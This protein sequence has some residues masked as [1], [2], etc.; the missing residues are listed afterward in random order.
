MP[1]GLRL[2]LI[3]ILFS[4]LLVPIA[5]GK[6]LRDPISIT[7]D[8]DFVT[9][10]F[11]GVGTRDN[12][13]RIEDLRIEAGPGR[14][15]CIAVE[16]TTAYFLIKNCELYS[17]YLGVSVMDV[18]P[19]TATIEGNIITGTTGDGGGITLSADGVTVLRNT[20]TNFVEGIHT[21]FAE[22][23]YILYNNFSQNEYHG[24]SL[25]YSNGN[26]VAHN[27]I[28]GNQ[29]HGVII[30][31]GSGN[32]ILFNNTFI[33]NSVIESYDWDD[34]YSFTVTSQGVDT[35]QS[36]KWYDEVVMMG[37]RWSDYSGEGEYA[38]DGE[39]RAVDKYPM[40]LTQDAPEAPEEP[41]ES[42]GGIPGYPFE[43]IILGLAIFGLIIKLVN[44]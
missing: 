11:P 20:C 12:P 4:L 17:S 19:D 41:E 39:G 26:L 27:I 44:R 35:A 8:E 40:Q 22:D 37:N 31:R 5:Q 16:G 6:E 2:V 29:A 38:I 30:I 21:N 10:G 24:V 18:A 23:C 13:Y 36:N 43:A 42:S 7:S 33:D 32:N 28:E 1:N 3:S 25:R 15:S 34:V 9:L 14:V